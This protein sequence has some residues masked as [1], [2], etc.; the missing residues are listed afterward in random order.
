MA[1]GL[2]LAL[3]CGVGC[4]RPFEATDTSR[5]LPGERRSLGPSAPPVTAEQVTTQNAHKIAQ[6][7]L[8]EMDREANE[9][10]ATQTRK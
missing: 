8:D 5:S 4:F 7:L 1:F 10:E 6:A 2:L 9:E 3:I